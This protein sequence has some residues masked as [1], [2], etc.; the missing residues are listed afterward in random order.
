MMKELL[1]SLLLFSNFLLFTNC[2][3]QYTV[4]HSFND[5]T[6][7]NPLG[8][9]TLL[10]SKLYG[11]TKY[12]GA[13]KNGCVFSIDTNGKK[14]KDL[15][16]FDSL[17]GKN[18]FGSLTA[19]KGKLY[20]MTCQGGTHGVGCIF[21]LDTN[22]SIYKDLLDFD[23][24]NG[25]FPYGNLTLSGS[26]MYGM[27]S[28]GG[29]YNFGCIFSIDTNGSNYQ[30]IHDFSGVFFD[31]FPLGSLILYRNRLYGMT[32]EEGSGGNIFSIDTNGSGYKNLLT[33]DTMQVTA[34]DY[35]SLIISGKVLYG[36]TTEVAPNINNFPFGNVFSIDTNGNNYKD[37]F[38]YNVKVSGKDP[39]GSL[40]LMGK[41]LYGMTSF[42][43]VNNG[44][45]IFAV[46]TN[47]KGYK[48]MH[49]F[50]KT[51]SNGTSPFGSLIFSGST[52][53]GM[54]YIG[55]TYGYG[56][57]FKID[58]DAGAGIDNL[59]ADKQTIDIYPNPSNGQFTFDFSTP[60]NGTIEIYDI[61]GRRICQQ[62]LQSN[63]TEIN[64]GERPAGMYFYRVL[65]S[66]GSL[67]GEGKVLKE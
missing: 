37:L 20:G 22:G 32:G 4:L 46:D 47:G 44:G 12:G 67:I 23:S 52:L 48:N 15:L 43:T 19:L 14:F 50:G 62:T 30:D 27:T 34:A 25:A 5:T 54:T 2:K 36:M 57:I 26:K 18:P 6:G 29:I 38:N 65:T 1:V 61:A 59:L 56:V 7:A 41:T 3:A 64:L 10:G 35:G 53:Y 39:A 51:I 13:F 45:N 17:N 66:T 42:A 16:D 31:E 58:S 28:G 63:K 24:T 55:G 40:V 9:L 33:F 8:D 21:S 11:M 49:D 60:V